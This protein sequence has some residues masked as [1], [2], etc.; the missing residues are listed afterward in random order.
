MVSIKRAV[1]R[2]PMT[3]DYATSVEAID[4]VRRL[5]LEYA[6]F[7]KV[8]LCFQ[9][10]DEELATLPGA[11]ALPTGRLITARMDGQVAG[12]VAIRPFRS[13]SC[14]MKRLFVLPACT[15]HGLGRALAERAISDARAMGYRKM[16]LDTLPSMVAALSLYSSLGFARCDSYYE[17]PLPGTLFMELTL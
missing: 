11:Y 17:T 13:G 2:S 14:E 15:G 16:L 6:E 1:R 9:G 7:L 8:D 5:F 10:F 4:E 12:C 3:I